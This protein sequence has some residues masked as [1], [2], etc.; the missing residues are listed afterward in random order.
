M[1]F[2]KH[3][4]FVKVVVAILLILQLCIIFVITENG[5]PSLSSLDLDLKLNLNIDSSSSTEK[6]VPKELVNKIAKLYQAFRYDTNPDWLDYYSLNENLLKISVGPRKN[7]TWESIDDIRFYDSDPRLSWSVYLWH[8]LDTD[9]IDNNDFQIPFSWYDWADFHNLNKLISLERTQLSCNFLY[10]GAFDRELLNSLEKE[11]K[12]PLFHEA[13]DK[14]LKTKWYLLSKKISNTDIFSKQKLKNYC[15][16]ILDPKFSTGLNVTKLHYYVRSEVFQL[17]T[18]NFLLTTFNAPLSLTFLERDKNS[19]QINLMQNNN[20]NLIQSNLLHNYVDANKK[21][22]TDDILF[23]HNE[24][25]TKFLSNGLLTSR[26]KVKIDEL[27]KKAFDHDRVYLSPSDFEFDRT[28]KIKELNARRSEL[29]VHELS[30]LK[31]LEHEAHTNPALS[32]KH[33]EEAREVQ[34]YGLMGHH[35]DEKFFYGD[36]LLND[37]QEYFNRLNSMI[38]TFQKFT[39]S[40]GIVSWLGHGTLYGHIYNG[41]TFPWDNDFDLQMPIKHLNYMAQHFNQSLILE[42]PREGNGRYMLDVSSSITV[43]TQG[44]GNNNIDARFIDIDSGLYIDITGLSVSSDPI[45]HAIKKYYEKKAKEMHFDWKK[46]RTYIENDVELTPENIHKFNITQLA[47]YMSDHR[48][49]FEGGQVDKVKDMAKKEAT[50]LPKSSQLEKNLNEKERYDLHKKAKIYNCRNDHFVSFDAI[51]PLINTQF[52]G[53]DA[54]IPNKYITVLK[55]EYNV[56]EDFAYIHFQGKTFLPQLNYWFNDGILNKITN[57]KSWYSTKVFTRLK[58]SKTLKELK[59]EDI[60]IMLNNLIK[61]EGDNMF[62]NVFNSFQTSAYKLKELEIENDTNMTVPLK[63]NYMR[64]MKTHIAPYLKNPGKDPVIFRYL[65]DNYKDLTAS[66]NKTEIQLIERSVDQL[67]VD[68]FWD[69]LKQQIDT[70]TLPMF[71]IT[72]IKEDEEFSKKINSTFIDLNKIGYD[73][74]STAKNKIY[75][76]DPETD[77]NFANLY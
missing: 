45:D 77:F 6:R 30:Y 71:N 24:W 4:S 68:V 56:P 46:E 15:H 27:D 10:E 14:Y 39:K 3:Y 22:K 62:S 49:D 75:K 12:E 23:N 37:P 53:V 55:A 65:R 26:F 18:R 32:P 7:Q 2:G 16:K 43:R 67:Y 54:L 47:T 66:L 38:R 34:Q 76:T 40:N 28:A 36:N 19:F 48:G 44:N 5:L 33:F 57:L 61:V 9:E 50:E 17:Q 52:H 74:L 70:K 51:S 35:R 58:A 1:D 73:L 31:S 60:K 21:P 8:L 72:N 20:K 64:K 11:I 41:Q 42:D 29:S 13:H 63:R 69:Q 59:L 25:Y